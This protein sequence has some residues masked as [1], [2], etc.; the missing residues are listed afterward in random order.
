M[1]L[2][3]LSGTIKIGI[4]ERKKLISLTQTVRTEVRDVYRGMNEFK[5]G[6]EWLIYARISIVF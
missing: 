4:S 2:V 1:K 6:L 3:E 5:K